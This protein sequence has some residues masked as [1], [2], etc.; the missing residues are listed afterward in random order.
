[1][2]FRDCEELREKLK[3]ST[4]AEIGPKANIIN[5]LLMETRDFSLVSVTSR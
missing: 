3:L 5:V 4:F 1:M 2:N